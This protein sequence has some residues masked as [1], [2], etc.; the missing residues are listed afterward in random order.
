MRQTSGALP[1]VLGVGLARGVIELKQFAREKEAVIFTFTFPALLLVLLGSI[2]SDAYGNT[3]VT[4]SQVFA[5]SMIAYGIM[6]TTFVT[7]GTGIATDREDG[8]LKR[9]HGAPVSATSYFVG[10][11]V[12]ITVVTV[13]EIVLMLAVGMLVFDMPLPSTGERWLT[14]AWLL[15]LSVVSC[16]LLGIAVSAMVKSVRSAGAVTT[17]PV[18]VLSFLSG[19]FMQP[20]NELPDWMLKVSSAFPVKW[21]GQGFRSVFLPDSMTR[22]EAA[23]A[24]EPGMTA[25][26]IGAW[27]VIGLMLC[28]LTFRWTNRRDG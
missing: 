15:V 22:W 13:A 6:N 23:A 4:A 16:T 10:K 26:V 25:L 7:M 24:W 27:C 9:L 8:T 17:V 19:V 20:I 1:S 21:I 11:I 18:V 2:F 12:L 28:L 3:G 5:A 14:F